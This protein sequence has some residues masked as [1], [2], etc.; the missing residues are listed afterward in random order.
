MVL[1]IG[2]EIW[3]AYHALIIGIIGVDLLAGIKRGHALTF[4]EASKWVA[5]W[6]TIGILFGFFVLFSFGAEAAGLYYAVYVIE[7]TLTL[8]NLFVF[9]II[10]SYFGVPKEARPVVLYAGILGAIVMRAGFIFGGLVL[11]ERFSFMVFVFGAILFYSGIKLA[12][13]GNETI[14][15][16]K[17]PIVRW[18]KRILPISDEYEGVKFM[19]KKGGKLMFTPLLIVLLMIESSDIMFAFDSVPAALAITNE[20]FLA[21]TANISAILGIRSLYFLL[22]A[23]M[24]KLRYINKGLAIILIFLGTKFFLG[25]LNIHISTVESLAVIFTILIVSIVTSLVIKPKRSKNG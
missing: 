6:V 12:R 13:A 21:Y 10:F 1:T 4:K 9:M 22:D 5:L 18:A 17:S 23:S 14:A 24:L 15:V 2:P 16:E 3:I 7:Y 19:V 20:F 25:G 11:I 8:D